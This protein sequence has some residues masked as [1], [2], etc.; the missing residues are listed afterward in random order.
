[1]IIH[2]DEDRDAAGYHI[3]WHVVDTT[4]ATTVADLKALSGNPAA[5]AQ[6]GW[7]VPT[8]HPAAL[9]GETRWGMLKRQLAAAPAADLLKGANL[10]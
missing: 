9:A 3:A 7:S 1:M 4:D 2:F 10:V 5:L 6:A 8:K